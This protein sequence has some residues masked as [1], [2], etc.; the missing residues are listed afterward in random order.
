MLHVLPSQSHLFGAVVEIGLCLFFALVFSGRLGPRWLRTGMK[1]IQ[2]WYYQSPL[3]VLDVGRPDKNVDGNQ[4][5]PSPLSFRVRAT[6]YLIPGCLF[7][8]L[9]LLWRLLSH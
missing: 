5:P 4:L 2:H 9:I 6:L 8:V 3:S 1:R 7:I